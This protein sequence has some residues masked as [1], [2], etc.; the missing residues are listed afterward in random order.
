M[1]IFLAACGGENAL[2]HA[3]DA[4]QDSIAINELHQKDM[5][6]V[7]A[8]DT[9]TLMSLWTD[10][11]VS[12]PP[13]GPIQRGR[14]ANAATLRAGMREAAGID[15]TDYRLSFDEL[16]IRGDIAIEWGSYASRARIKSND[17]V[18]TGGGKLMRVL[19][20][21]QDGS[22]LVWRTIYTVD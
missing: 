7:V 6:A 20:R 14:Q 3:A 19:R 15:P 21:Q 9:A 8:G 13:T 18:V 16:T 4:A 2:T 10:D 12:L 5:R 11:I 22:W 17:S 1:M